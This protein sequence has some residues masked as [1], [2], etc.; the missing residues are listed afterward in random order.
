MTASFLPSRCENNK[1]IIGEVSKFVNATEH[2]FFL[3]DANILNFRCQ[4][5]NSS[6][7]F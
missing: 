7:F 4:L 1:E 6:T 5:Q 3:M 2:N